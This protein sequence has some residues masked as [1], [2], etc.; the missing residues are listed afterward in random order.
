MSSGKVYDL[1]VGYSCNNSCI[2]CV[3]KP[4][5]D[6][7]HKNGCSKIDSNYKEIIECMNSKEFI[8]A[9]SITITGG[10]PTLRKEF[11]RIIKY[12]VATYPNKHINLQTNGRLLINHLEE[13]H[14]ITKNITYVIA[15]HSTDESIHNRVVGNKNDKGN[16]FRETMD[17]LNQI[18]KVYGQ[19]KNTARIEIV[20]SNINYKS[21]PQTI[22]DLYE[23]DIDRIGIS[24][25][26]LDGF[27]YQDGIERVKDISLS[28]EDLKTV[29]PEMYHYT[30]QNPN[31]ILEL[32]EVPI[33]MFR[34]ENVL[35]PPIENISAMGMGDTK[36][37][38]KFPEREIE[39]NFAEIWVNMH[40]K[41]SKCKECAFNNCC[42]GVWFEAIETFGDLGFVPVTEE[43]TVK[44]GLIKCTY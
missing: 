28:Y 27:Y 4:N 43:E 23:M 35:L 34:D 44:R 39:N 15:L 18:K 17:T 29:L 21:V 6:N 30:K 38:V 31:L 5:V 40:K 24:Y 32:E 10:E 42:Y 22:K 1:K 36:V 7:I 13:L 25:P 37:S 19:F 8:E 20:L 14:S 3:I 16:P 33:C 2:H 9:D 26:H 12:I 11:M 41:S